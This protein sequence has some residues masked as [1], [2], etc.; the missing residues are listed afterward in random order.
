M[1]EH[2]S[3]IEQ[4]SIYYQCKKSESD[5]QNRERKKT[6]YGLQESIEQTQYQ[7]HY[8]SRQQVFRSHSGKNMDNYQQC[9]AVYKPL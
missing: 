5:Y 6:K 9:N 8:N 7:R 4:E 3:E 1:N 2:R